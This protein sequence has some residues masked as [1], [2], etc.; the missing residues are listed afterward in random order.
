MPFFS[1]VLFCSYTINKMLTYT[2]R[3]NRSDLS[4]LKNT[5]THIGEQKFDFKIDL[6]LW[7][8]ISIVY[9]QLTTSLHL[10]YKF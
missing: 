7:I 9:G 2:E 1:G 3:R 8:W 6:Q 10:L 5:P 4:F